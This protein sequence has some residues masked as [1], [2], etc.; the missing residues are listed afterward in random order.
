MR[1][2]MCAAA[3]A[4]AMAAGPA[5]AQVGFYLTTPGIELGESD[6]AQMREVIGGALNEAEIDEVRTWQNDETGIG[7]EVRVLD[8]STVDETA[9]AETQITLRSE[10]RQRA[11]DLLFCQRP[12]GTW[13]IA[14]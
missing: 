10:T 7:G 14:G 12:D 6:R 4:L 3:A 8:R 5:A 9:C 11:F 1:S 13:G 2:L